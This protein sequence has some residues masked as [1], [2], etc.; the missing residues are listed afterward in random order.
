MKK[1]RK[2]NIAGEILFLLGIIILWQIFYVAGVDG[3]GIWKAYAMPSP[4]GVWNSFVEMMKQGTLLAAIGNSILRG[5]IG[6][7]LSLIIGA[8]IGILINHFSFLHRNLRPLIIPFSSLWFGLTQTAI[9]FVVIMG[10]AFSMAIAVDNAILNVPPIYK[11]AA[12]TM[13]ANQKQIYWKVIFPASLPE[14]ISGMK[15]GWSF[16]WRALMSGEVMTT[17]IGLGQT[18]MTGRNLADINQVMLVMVVIVVV[19]ILIDQVVF[20]NVEKRVLKKRGL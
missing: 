18:L 15:Q 6:Y 16:A 3:L 20:Y 2:S 7:I 11:K 9:I 17:S 14:L 1:I 8:V 10:S 4:V 13:G 12:L 5:A 19:G